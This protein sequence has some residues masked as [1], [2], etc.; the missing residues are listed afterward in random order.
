MPEALWVHREIDE[1]VNISVSGFLLPSQLTSCPKGASGFA[2]LSR[3]LTLPQSLSPDSRSEPSEKAPSSITTRSRIVAYVFRLVKRQAVRTVVS[4]ARQRRSTPQSFPRKRESTPQ[5]SVGAV[6]EPP[7]T[8]YRLVGNASPT[9]WI[10]AF[11]GMTAP[12]SARLA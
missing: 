4:F 6:R 1:F 2:A 12:R 8:F 11:A 10:P 7:L 3:R 5:T 9:D